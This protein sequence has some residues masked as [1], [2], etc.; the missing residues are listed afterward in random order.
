MIKIFLLL[1]FIAPL[2]AKNTFTPISDP[3]QLPKS[4]LELWQTY[5]ARA[6][7]LEVEVIEEWKTDE[8]M[9]M[10]DDPI[11]QKQE[12]PWWVFLRTDR[13][14]YIRNLL[15]GE[16]EELY[17]MK[18]DPEE[19]TNLAMKEANLSLLRKFRQQAINELERTDCKFANQMP[20]VLK[21]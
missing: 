11:Y 13:Y 6:E 1:S 3:E 19:L 17:D 16:T 20:P 9:D 2:G 8:V 18:E 10:K 21:P 14:K 5:D 7:D 15:P 12:V 4:A